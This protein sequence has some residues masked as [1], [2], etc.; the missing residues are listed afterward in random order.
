MYEGVFVPP[1]TDL[2][3]TP[4]RIRA[5]IRV[6]PGRDRLGELQSRREPWGAI[7]TPQERP[8]AAQGRA[9]ILLIDLMFHFLR[10]FG[11]MLNNFITDPLLE[12]I[13]VKNLFDKHKKLKCYRNDLPRHYFG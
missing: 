7:Q 8:H 11:E 6:P 5:E 12:S 13:H 4:L 3:R 10:C 1:V 2:S 9:W